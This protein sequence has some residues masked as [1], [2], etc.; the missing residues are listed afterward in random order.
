MRPCVK[1][2]IHGRL[3]FVVCTPTAGCLGARQLSY[4]ISKMSSNSPKS[5]G[6]WL[7]RPYTPRHAQWPYTDRDFS[8]SNSCPDLDFYNTP[9]FVTH[10]DA[11][12]IRQLTAYYDFVMPRKG[13]ILDFCSSWVS[14]YPS[15]I[16]EAQERREVVV[17]GA[18]LNGK[19]LERNVL[20]KEEG[21]RIVQDLN[22]N[23]DLGPAI[24]TAAT[25]S[26]AGQES[27]GG[28]NCILSAATCVVSIDYLA[29]PLNVL[30]SI[31]SAMKPGAMIHI[32][33][34]N[35]A[36]WDKVIRRWMEVDE[37]ERLLVIADYLHFAGFEGI[38]IV[39]VCMAKEE[40]AQSEGLME[41]L[42]IV[43]GGGDPLWVVRGRTPETYG[44]ETG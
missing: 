25:R 23:P 3:P 17:I 39:E 41:F 4:Y 42:G 34:S 27:S 20:L 1:S 11:K 22:E 31:R 18:G 29:K 5:K 19:E 26:N 10:I 30:K 24:R 40:E 44:K 32:A 33:I 16:T 12:A 2:S 38:E 28:E 36:F 37:D 7:A 15:W 21:Q 14:H 6:Q 13:T 8:R 9:R 35:R 43:R